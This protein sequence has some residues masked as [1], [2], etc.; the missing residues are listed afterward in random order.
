[1][2]CAGA[3]A[4][5]D[6]PCRSVQGQECMGVAR[7]VAFSWFILNDTVKR[8]LHCCGVFPHLQLPTMFE[9]SEQATVAAVLLMFIVA[10]QAATTD[11]RVLN[12]VQPQKLWTT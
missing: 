2:S 1:M 6:C 5:D 8:R 12:W 3:D 7:M 10:G 9:S 11:A 4:K